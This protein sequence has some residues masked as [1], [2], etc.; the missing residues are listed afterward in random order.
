M[1]RVPCAILRCSSCG[2]AGEVGRDAG[3][4]HLQRKAVLARE[5]I[6]GGA[7]GQHIADHLHRDGLRVGRNAFGGDAVQLRRNSR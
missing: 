1:L 4:H 2:C 6:D 7:A 5:H 3:V